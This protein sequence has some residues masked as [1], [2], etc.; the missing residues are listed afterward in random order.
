MLGSISSSFFA[1]PAPK[2][3]P[4]QEQKSPAP[5]S[6]TQTS[7]AEADAEATGSISTVPASPA[8]PAAPFF[9]EGAAQAAAAPAQSVP[10]RAGGDNGA[11]SSAADSKTARTSLSDISA[12]TS[13]D[14]A[15]QAALA[16]QEAI[17]LEA[18]MD[19][20]K[21]I[22]P[23]SPFNLGNASETAGKSDIDSVRRAYQEAMATA[24]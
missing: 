20:L 18:M 9:V 2:L 6:Q 22:K 8:A 16:I 15:R 23:A 21:D 13:V 1:Q 5:T 17:K 24:A 7:P 12:A 3:Q 19:G 4:V 11:Q 14:D 10:A